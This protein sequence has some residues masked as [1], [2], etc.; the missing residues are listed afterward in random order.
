M[1]NTLTSGNYVTAGNTVGENIV[2]L[3]T[4]AKANAD[5]IDEEARKRKYSV[6]NLENA[7]KQL[8]ANIDNEAAA[9]RKQ[10]I[11]CRPISITKQQ[12]V[13]KQIRPCR[14]ISTTKLQPVKQPIP[15]WWKPS[16]AD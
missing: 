2:A 14:P 5:A 11:P 6:T 3:D 13:K 10:T 9:V 15:N 8:Q 1:D 7:D 12:P 16:I 4:Q